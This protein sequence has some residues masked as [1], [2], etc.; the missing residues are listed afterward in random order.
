M[1]Y[2]KRPDPAIRASLLDR[3]ARHLL[4]RGL[5]HMSLAAVAAATGTSARMLVYHFGSRDQLVEE[6]RARAQAIFRDDTRA[7]FA[8]SGG[9]LGLVDAAWRHVSR[10]L[11][12]AV[13]RA[14]FEVW[15]E[16]LVTERADAYLA[17]FFEEL[18]GELRRR[19]AAEGLANADTEAI[20]EAAVAGLVGLSERR[21]SQPS[22]RTAA[23][24]TRLRAWLASE[25]V[26]RRRD[27]KG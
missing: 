10:T 19:H 9:S 15:G 18:A 17:V 23:G 5:G 21:L 3:A 14:G 7:V 22:R 20:A 1:N 26:S 24:F 12:P 11:S 8:A 25:A 6:A 13:L 16:A 27:G 4:E 2:V